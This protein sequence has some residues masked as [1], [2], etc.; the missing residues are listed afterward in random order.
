MVLSLKEQEDFLDMMDSKNEFSFLLIKNNILS[1][2]IFSHGKINTKKQNGYGYEHIVQQRYKQF[3]IDEIC[4]FLIFSVEC[5]KK[6][7]LQD[8]DYGAEIEKQSKRIY[9]NK[10]GLRIVLSQNQLFD[11]NFWVVTSFPIVENEKISK[12]IEDAIK[13][14]NAS[15]DYK[16]LLSFIR[17]EVGALI[18]SKLNINKN[19]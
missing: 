18:F 6:T 3:T 8:I 16:L 17:K 2:V 14:V 5:I 7:T 13:T 10:D 4:S 12:K 15:N 11:K 1:E 19:D 9:I